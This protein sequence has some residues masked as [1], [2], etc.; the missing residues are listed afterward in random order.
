MAHDLEERK[1]QDTMASGRKTREEVAEQSELSAGLAEETVVICRAEFAIG[2]KSN[3][4]RLFRRHDELRLG[5]SE[6]HN[7][8][9]D[10]HHSYTRTQTLLDAL[11]QIRV[12]GRLAQ[13]HEYVAQ[14]RCLGSS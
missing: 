5:T 12:V 3:T 4:R 7:E 6:R 11:E 9:G 1:N 14:T 10:R 13:L 8:C 2:L